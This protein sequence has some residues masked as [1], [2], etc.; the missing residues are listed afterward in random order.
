MNNEWAFNNKIKD[1]KKYVNNVCKIKID[2]KYFQHL[3]TIAHTHKFTNRFELKEF[4]LILSER[5]HGKFTRFFFSV[6]FLVIYV[7]ID[8]LSG[9]LHLF[10]I[11]ERSIFLFSNVITTTIETMNK[12]WTS[13]LAFSYT[14]VDC[15]LNK[16]TRH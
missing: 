4:N 15:T 1:Y 16:P 5:N 13:H 9:H 14:Q 10:I 11:L 6:N 2:V 12:Y 8:L 7:W 3:N